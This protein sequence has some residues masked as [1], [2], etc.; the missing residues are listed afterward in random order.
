M[1]I[2]WQDFKTRCVQNSLSVQCDARDKVYYLQAWDGNLQLTS[3]VDKTDPKN[4]DQTDF[5]TNFLPTINN[6]VRQKVDV[7]SSAEPEPFAKP[8]YRTKRN[9]N[10][11]WVTCP[12][13]Q[14][15]PIDFELE[16]ER[17]VTG[18][19]FIYKDAQEGDYITADVVD[20]NGVIPE[21]YR[22]ILCENYPVVAR[23]VEKI[24][25]VPS[26]GYDFVTM[27]TYPLNAKIT[28][29]L[30]LRITYHAVDS[31]SARKAAVNYNL[32]KKLP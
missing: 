4:S 30:F 32:T 8:T 31:G 3:W 13:N 7:V 15:T 9:A 20:V 16:E 1:K 21:P 25:L 23:Y 24:W 12:A 28:Q 14:P 18:G 5:E 26:V 11:S 27:D 19:K 17:W 29:G 2:T 22:A 10:P 6:T